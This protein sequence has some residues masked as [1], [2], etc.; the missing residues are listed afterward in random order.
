MRKKLITPATPKVET[1]ERKWLDLLTLARAE[2]TSEDPAHPIESALH[3]IG[4][5]GWRALTPGRQTIRLLF[6]EPLQIRHLHL[7]FQ[8]DEEPRTQEF[9]LRWSADAGRSYREIVRQQYN[10]NPP[11]T[12]REA[13]DYT[14]ELTGVTALELIIIPDISGGDLRASLAQLC[15]A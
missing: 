8:E 2:L 1:T 7:E 3:R 4:G 15:L 14:V 5:T 13:E 9:V 6:D 11:D 12:I 10:F